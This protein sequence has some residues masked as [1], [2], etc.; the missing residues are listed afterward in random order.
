MR[1]L[2][3]ELPG[4]LLVEPERL[5]DHRGFFARTW[6]SREF[7]DRGLPEVM[8]QA[9]ISFNP[10]AGT[11]RG[12]HYALPPCKEGKLVRC[13]A[14]KILDVVADIRPD[15]RTFMQ[16]FKVELDAD[17]RTAIYIP[18]GFAHGFLTL[19]SDSEILYMMTEEYSPGSAAGFRWNDPAFRIEWP[20][21]EMTISE[22]DD[23]YPDF[24]A[25][26]VRGFAGY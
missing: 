20:K 17:N 5:A 18:P 12:M 22:R 3:T 15:S 1:F 7:A 14:G 24:D 9:S 11:L 23:N 6:C 25:D 2:D 4:L 13:L 8:K 16:H 21:I 26:S 10:A 19:E